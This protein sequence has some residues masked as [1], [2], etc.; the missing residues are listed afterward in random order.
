MSIFQVVTL[1][2]PR[3]LQ[4]R[5]F[6]G[7]IILFLSNVLMASGNSSLPNIIVIMTDDQGRWSLGEYDNRLVFT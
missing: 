5:A 3:L 6:C 7:V 4:I 2:R 1:S